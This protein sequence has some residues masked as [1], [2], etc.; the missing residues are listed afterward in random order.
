MN[1]KS[2][3]VDIFDSQ[4]L[5]H[6]VNCS[7]AIKIARVSSDAYYEQTLNE[8]RICSKIG[9]HINICTMLGYVEGEHITCL[10][11]E[12][13]DTSLSQALTIMRDDVQQ[14]RRNIE[15]IVKY[16]KKIA[17]QIAN[18]MVSF[19]TVLSVYDS[20]SIY[21]TMKQYQVRKFW[22]HL[23]NI[24]GKFDIFGVNSNY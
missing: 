21:S 6:F 14:N 4:N 11:L 13:A 7:I 17:V 3:I 12:L 1:Q 19:E 9:Y 24:V 2:P 22:L 16:L 15:D 8:I 18:G 10:L 5:S 23:K 20:R